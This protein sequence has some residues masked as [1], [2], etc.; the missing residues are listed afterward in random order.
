VFFFL[1][2]SHCGGFPLSNLYLPNTQ[3]KKHKNRL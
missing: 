3:G 2:I 1:S